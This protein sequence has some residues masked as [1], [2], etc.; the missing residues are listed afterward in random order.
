MSKNGLSFLIG[1]AA[2]LAIGVL[3]APRAGAQTRE[4]IRE[5]IRDKAAE[6][7]NRAKDYAAESQRGAAESETGRNRVPEAAGLPGD[8]GTEGY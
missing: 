6:V 4:R 3:T 5:D 2:G 7:T 8:P 1:L